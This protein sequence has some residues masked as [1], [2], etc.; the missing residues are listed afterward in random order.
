MPVLP[1]QLHEQFAQ[2]L[3]V[4]MRST[5]A[6]E[7]AT[8]VAGLGASDQ[9]PEGTGKGRKGRGTTGHATSLQRAASLLKAK[10]E[11]QARVREIVA[12]AA[13]K[14]EISVERVL[15]ELACIGFA[16]L[17]D[18]IDEN[19]KIV[20]FN[21]LPREKLA[22]LQE[23]T[24]SEI[25]QGKEVVGTKTKIKLADK[26]GALVELGRHMGLFGPDFSINFNNTQNNVNVDT[27][28]AAGL[29][30]IMVGLLEARKAE[31]EKQLIDV[32][33]I[34]VERVEDEDPSA[35]AGKALGDQVSGE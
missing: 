26:K 25:T 5:M 24:V 10:P 6:Y 12:H 18:Y 11:V 21:K 27:A 13:V 7:E 15:V 9:L 23:V 1:N 2:K 3:A 17:G 35:L 8:K 29:E 19:G 4:G 14:A 33:P 20:D 31:R 28:D 16:N 30:R 32:T 22:A 34:K